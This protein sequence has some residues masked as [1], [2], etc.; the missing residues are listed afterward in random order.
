MIVRS[1]HSPSRRRCSVLCSTFTFYPPHSPIDSIPLLTPS[2]H[3]SLSVRP[4]VRR[5]T[6]AINI[7][8]FS[9]LMDRC[10]FLR[11]L[12]IIFITVIP[13]LFVCCTNCLLSLSGRRHTT[14][15]DGKYQQIG[16]WKAIAADILNE[17]RNASSIVV[18]EFDSFLATLTGS[19]F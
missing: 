18:A 5:L 3:S 4:S 9:M 15:R 11:L 12:A 10:P 6:W 17:S 16:G 2:P 14:S 13:G 19:G 1:D 8:Y 7:L